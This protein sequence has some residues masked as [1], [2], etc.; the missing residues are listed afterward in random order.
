MTLRASS[1]P[2]AIASRATS[3]SDV[4]VHGYEQWGIHAPARAHQRDVRVR[5]LGREAPHAASSR[6]TGSARSRST[7]G[8]TSGRFLFAS[9][10]KA[11]W[12]ADPGGWQRAVRTRS[13]ASSI[14]RTCPGRETI[15]ADAFQLLARP[16]ADG[17]ARRPARGALL[18]AVVRPQGRGRRSTTSSVEADRVVAAAVRRRLRSD[19]PLGAFLSGGVD[20]GIVV[21]CMAESGG[22]DGPYVLDG[23]R[24]RRA[25]RAQLCAARRR[26]LPDRAHRVRGDGRCVGIAAAARV[27]V[28]PA[29]RRRG[30]HSDVLRREE[31]AAARHGGVDRATAATSRSPA[32]ASTSDASLGAAVGSVL[33][34]SL[35]DR[36]RVA[37]R[38]CSTPAIAAGRRRRRAFCA[39]PSSDPLGELGRLDH[40]VAA[41]PARALGGRRTAGSPTATCCSAMRSRSAPTST[42]DSALDRAPASRPD[43]ALALRLQ[44]EG[45]RRHHDEQPR[46][47]LSLPGSR[48]RGVGRDRA[49]G[50]EAPA[51][52]GEIAARRRSRRGGF[53]ARSS[54]VRST[55]SRFRT[56][57]GFA[58]RGRRRRARSSS[59]EQARSRGFFDFAYL[60]R[61]VAGACAGTARA[62]HAL[63]AAALARALVPD[64]R[65]PH[66]SDP[67]TGCRPWRVG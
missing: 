59:P 8:G 57:R 54:T 32:T 45:R 5:D 7:T 16:P 60:E 30:L 18:A 35:L 17:H 40:V 41:S 53:R 14:G 63:L 3:D 43:G 13:R 49:R 9:E 11:L 23:H 31:R 47:A 37:A 64:L 15:Y 62:R 33:P 20:S 55:A 12:I 1:S 26:A 58:A 27:G 6:A 66:R 65:R 51:V 4:L 10:L 56:T 52:G 39:T 21:S 61:L 29:L 48:G 38:R 67:T 24:R 2:P 25:R 44:P 22:A 19:V 50:G 42:A 36:W 46:G 34:S 28:R